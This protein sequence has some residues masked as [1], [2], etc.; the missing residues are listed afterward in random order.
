MVFIE[1]RICHPFDVILAARDE[2][3]TAFGRKLQKFKA[4]FVSRR[5]DAVA[6][7]ERLGI[8]LAQ[9]PHKVGRERF[10]VQHVA[11]DRVRDSQHFADLLA[12]EFRP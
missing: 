1:Q 10:T 3:A 9:T 11:F 2:E 8:K 12:V 4:V 7:L 6:A 5:F